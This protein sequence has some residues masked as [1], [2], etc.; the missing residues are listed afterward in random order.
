MSFVI[1]EIF[2]F[3]FPGRF[4]SCQA[5]GFAL[6]TAERPPESRA[7]RRCGRRD[8]SAAVRQRPWLI[9]G[10]HRGRATARRPSTFRYLLLPAATCRQCTRSPR[11]FGAWRLG[12]AVWS[13]GWK[14]GLGDRAVTGCLE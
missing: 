6:W 7:S 1:L 3:H 5:A 9:A 2:L 12:L 11:H 14:A 4:P 8:G 10:V 13:M